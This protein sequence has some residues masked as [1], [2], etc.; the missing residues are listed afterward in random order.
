MRIHSTVRAQVTL[1][2]EI[3]PQWT[4]SG[5]SLMEDLPL[6]S[7][8]PL[9]LLSIQNRLHLQV[10]SFQAFFHQNSSYVSCSNLLIICFSIIS[11]FEQI[12]YIKLKLVFPHISHFA[13]CW[14]YVLIL[15]SSS[16]GTAQCLGSILASCRRLHRGADQAAMVQPPYSGLTFTR[17][18]SRKWWQ[19][20]KLLSFVD[21]PA[22]R[23]MLI[24]VYEQG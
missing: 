8:E 16:N 20:K 9:T 2:D 23:N 10:P 7:G 18:S 6:N 17:T 22:C 19:T 15:F 11:H 21:Q 24:W 4:G 1:I 3:W 5:D 13:F 14:F 12:M